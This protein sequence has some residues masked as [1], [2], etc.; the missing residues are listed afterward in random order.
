MTRAPRVALMLTQTAHR[1]PGG[2]AVSVQRLAAALAATGRV[3]LTAVLARGDLRHP[4]SV[5]RPGP[6]AASMPDGVRPVRL[7]LPVPVLYDAWAHTGWPR[8]E[9]STGPVDLV[10]VTVPM[11]VGVGDVPVVATVHD[12]F[13][14]TRPGESTR[15]GAR[16]MAAGLEWI[17]RSARAV[18]V[19]SATVADACA[20]RGLDPARITVVPWGT[21][22]HRPAPRQ[23]SAVL[24]RQGL[25]GPYVLFVGT[26]EPR[27]NL[28][29]LVAAMARLDRPGVTL[30]LVGPTGWG[31]DLD[32]ALSGL[33]SPVARLGRVGDADLPA[34][35]AGAAAVCYPSFEEGFGLPVLEAMAAGAPV[36]TSAGTATADVAGDAA[37]L[38]DPRDASSIAAGLT[39]VL[40]DTDRAE[41]LRAAGERRAEQHSWSAAAELTL[42]VYRGV[43]ER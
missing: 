32:A 18:M 33:A 39:D 41:R 10:H 1:V 9:A 19:P 24:V 17:L 27:K 38:V 21:E 31:T 29:G 30:A 23:V 34:L 43:L 6:A 7:P 13:P 35:Y 20:D 42:G 8:V 15:R 28:E 2:T 36:V 5:L 11:R 22:V 16:L 40:D 3:E 4:A 25:T 26:V 37:V 14:L 12:L